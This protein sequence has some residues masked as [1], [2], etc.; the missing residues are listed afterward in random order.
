MEDLIFGDLIVNAVFKGQNIALK[1]VQVEGCYLYDS[2]QADK[3]DPMD[4]YEIV[5]D[6]RKFL[7]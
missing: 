6:I 7:S 1:F 2:C 4:E 5:C 3:L